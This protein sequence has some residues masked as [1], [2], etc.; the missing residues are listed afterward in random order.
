MKRLLK[1]FK[2]L[3]AAA[4]IAVL[5]AI[6][7]RPKPAA[8]EVGRVVQGPLT[9]TLDEEG[10]TRVRRRFVI[11]A[12][13]AGRVQRIDLEPGDPVVR[14]E[15][16]VA[17]FKPADPLPLDV[18]SR[19]EAEAA[20]K[21]AEAALGRARAERERAAA[22]ERLARA[23]LARTR[24]LYEKNIAARQAFESAES[25]AR[26]AEEA[27]RAAEFGAAS[28]EQEVRMARA[29]LLSASGEPGAEQA[30]IVLRSPIHGVVLKRLRE[31]E[32]VVPAG[33][34]LLE[35]GDPRQLEIV[36]DFLSTD[37][38]RIR[39]GD[40]VRIERWGGE[41]ALRGRVRRVEPSGFMKISALGVEEQ[42][43]GVVIDFD[44]PFEAWK[45][46]GDGY[47][48][49]VRV[50]VWHADSVLKVPESS[51][52]RHGSGWAV[53]TIE[54]DRA[55]LRPVQAGHRNGMEAQ[56]VQGLSEGE[57]VVLHPSDAVGD[58]VRV[59]LQGL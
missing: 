18:R 29:R 5:L 31:S 13:V 2:L 44:D 3:A 45:R 47:R 48:V 7:F 59:K 50:V 34:P 23:E 24:S 25:G 58:G 53:F 39:P 42:R 56:V 54:N 38:V 27:L 46:L 35:L 17:V 8:V 1:W 33:E 20:V 10:R 51:L 37:A 55:R 15:T 43:V 36:C 49:E 14:N 4:F 52:F 9:V 6:A 12:P 30:P 41:A 57:T 19:A 11:S 22:A 40:P 26:E 32:S 21:A 28:A 16:V